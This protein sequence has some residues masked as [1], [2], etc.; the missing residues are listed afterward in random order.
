MSARQVARDLLG[1]ALGAAVAW[2]L[3]DTYWRGRIEQDAG[4]LTWP[5]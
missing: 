5:D 4:T 3:S 1:V 2:F